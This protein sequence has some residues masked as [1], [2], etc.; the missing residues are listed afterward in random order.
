MERIKRSLQLEATMNKQWMKKGA[1]ALT[2]MSLAVGG[3]AVYAQDTS[4]SVVD[5]VGPGFGM[6][7]PGMRGFGGLSV[8]AE[9]LGI[10]QTE[11]WTELQ[12]GKTI[13]QLAEEKDVATSAIVDAVIAAHEE[14]L[15]T[16]VTDGTLTQAQADA[17]LALAKAD[18][19][20]LLDQTFEAQNMP[21]F[22]RRDGFGM[23]M[24][25]NMMSVIAEQLGIEQ[26][27]LW[28]EL[29]SGKTIAQL[30]EEKGV[31]TDAIVEAIVAAHKAVIDSAVAAG[32]LTQEQADS[33]L[34]LMTSHIQAMLDG[35][36]MTT[37]GMGGFG[38]RGDMGMGMGGHGMGMGGRGQG[39]GP[40][41]MGG[42]GQGMGPGGMGRFGN[43]PQATSTPNA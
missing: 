26:T 6:R 29:Q 4:P 38:P 19:E 11:L 24:G 14:W 22:G 23:G 9:T 3:V 21:G 1:M 7:G 41:G 10:E 36:M 17:R 30:A 42:R 20:V 8:V 28:T 43:A 15:T 31:S 5:P 32:T 33:R 12:S 34:E 40:G 35:T 16:A 27:A 37:G 2:V 13:A 18:A 25:V 39:M